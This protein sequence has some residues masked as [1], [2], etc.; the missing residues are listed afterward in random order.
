M[1]EKGYLST[2]DPAS[3]SPNLGHA[4][5]LQDNWGAEEVGAA[6]RVEKVTVTASGTS[7]VAAANIP[8]GA[9]II[10]VKVHAKA[11]VGSGSA[12]VKVGGDGG[13]AISNA[14]AMNTEDA[15]ARA[16]TIDQTYK[17]VGTNGITVVT[18]GDTDQG[19]VYIEYKKG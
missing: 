3:G 9:E 17:I 18:N 15:V 10:D 8:V 16:A 19:D 4:Q 1:S 12:Q 7:G 11:T 6:V 5:Y 2:D 14:I 13:A